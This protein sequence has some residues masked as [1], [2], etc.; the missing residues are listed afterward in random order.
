MLI[1][2][3]DV[4]KNQRSVAAA[5]PRICGQYVISGKRLR[6]ARH[7]TGRPLFLLNEACRCRNSPVNHCRSANGS[8]DSPGCSHCMTNC[9]FDGKQRKPPIPEY[10]FDRSKLHAVIVDSPGSVSAERLYFF[11]NHCCRLN[12]SLNSADQA[13]PGSGRSRDV[14]RIV[15]HSPPAQESQWAIVVLFGERT[16]HK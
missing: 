3:L 14:I 15:R 8:F 10:R 5:K 4:P 7:S 9:T 12:S 16:R 13:G 6:E 1:K 2:R 11:R